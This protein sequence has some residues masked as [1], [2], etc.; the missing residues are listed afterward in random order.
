[1]YIIY[2]GELNMIN[3]Q[4]VGIIVFGIIG[5][6]IG[7]ILGAIIAMAI[8]YFLIKRMESNKEKEEKG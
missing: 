4:A 2:K 8:V 3:K 1:M 5:Y 6:L 7:G